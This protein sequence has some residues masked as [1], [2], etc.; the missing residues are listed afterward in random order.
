MG[1]WF[2]NK[3]KTTSGETRGL[4]KKVIKRNVIV[5]DTS[6]TSGES[7]GI[8]D[9]KFF[10]RIHKDMRKAKLA[11]TVS[12]STSEERLAPDEVCLNNIKATSFLNNRTPSTRKVN[13]E[14]SPSPTF[15]HKGKMVPL[16]EILASYDTWASFERSRL[17]KFY[18]HFS[19]EEVLS[20][21]TPH[22]Y[23]K[24]KTIYQ[25][26]RLGTKFESKP[27]A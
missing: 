4:I 24:A 7:V 25:L 8:Y 13:P 12:D 20:A 18:P 17:A 6:R 16:R 11:S 3:P 1:K 26:N 19:K 15:S 22:N 21:T 5:E 2:T 9:D 23:A 10:A 27:P 14:G